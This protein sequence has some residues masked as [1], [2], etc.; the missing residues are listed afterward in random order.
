MQR[1]TLIHD[2]SDQGWQAAYLAFRIAAQL[3]APLLV[4][5]A[6]SASDKKMLAER[7][8]QVEVGG[9]AA[10]VAI[11]SHL[12]TDFS[13]DTVI[14]N[15]IKSNGLFA[16]RR[17]IPDEK[18]ARRFLEAFSCPLWIVSNESE[19]HGLSILVGEPD[20]D[21]A[22]IHYVTALAKRIQQP[23]T[24]LI[25]E[26]ELASISEADTDVN[27]LSLAA[28]SSVEIDAALNQLGSSLLFVPVS[29]LS[30]TEGLSVNY[31]ICPP[32]QDA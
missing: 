23:L 32:L 4:L 6:D 11:E 28:F 7:A 3:G 24:G 5:L 19:M 17:L 20:S 8:A 2:G 30:L 15:N 16:P 25:P 13:V 9:H 12:V 1:F 14:E 31:V 27:W 10:R 26:S 29:S 21:A 22:L 18:T